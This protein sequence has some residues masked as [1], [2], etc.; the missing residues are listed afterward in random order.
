M[1]KQVIIIRKDLKLSKGKI[2]AQCAHASL[3]AYK[4]SDQSTREKW[5]AE[6]MKKVVL[7]V[8]NL[9]ELRNV[10]A[11]ALKMNLP[12]CIIKDAG[13]TEIQRGTITAVGIGPDKEE[14]IDKITKHLKLL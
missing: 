10:Y 1:Y 4:K 5:E 8:N 11:S 14:A 12:A 13:R 2:A 3:D 9:R 7:K 6:G